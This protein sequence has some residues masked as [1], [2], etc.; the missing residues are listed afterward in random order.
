MLQQCDWTLVH[1]LNLL[2][3]RQCAGTV[4]VPACQDSWLASSGPSNNALELLPHAATPRLPIQ[5]SPAAS[6]APAPGSRCCLSAP[7]H[8]PLPCSL[9]QEIRSD[10]AAH[11][12]LFLDDIATYQS[13]LA[14]EDT[15][16]KPLLVNN[17]DT[18]K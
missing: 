1:I 11:P 5:A 16:F 18:G 17:V 3:R 15:C 2:P 12:Y 10:P 4:G 8:S 14:K 9:S 13:C 7:A 6:A